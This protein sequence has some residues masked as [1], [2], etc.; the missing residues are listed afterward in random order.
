MPIYLD[1]QATTPVDAR[2]L[3]RMWPFFREKFG[4]AASWNHAFGQEAAAAVEQARQQLATLLHTTPD[5]LVFTS[6]AT[7]ANNL[8]LKGL[9]RRVPAGKHVVTTAI[10]HK[11]ILDPL[12]R[13][14]RQGTAVTHVPVD[15]LGRVDP[16]RIAAAIRP[17]TVL[18]SVMWANNEVG[19]IQPI[20]EIAEL[21]RERGVLFHTDAAQAVGKLSVD[22]SETPIDLLSLSAHKFYGPKGVGA[23][24]IRRGEPRI[25]LEP[26]FDGGGHEQH[27]RSGT[28]AVP[29]I[30][31]LG[32]AAE[33]AVAEQEAEGQ[34]LTWLAQRLWERLLAV[35]P[36][37]QRNGHP[38]ERIPGNLHISI[39]EINGA[40]LMTRLTEVAV[41]SG[42][43]CTTADPEP[44]HVLRA[45]G[46]PER[47]A[48]AS[49]RF[50]LGRE[51]TPA[52]V[53]FAAEYIGLMVRDLLGPAV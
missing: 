22:L 9:L 43:A 37:V 35:V 52:E 31:G 32:A 30:V 20:R 29:L 2:V 16:A 27:L 17:E 36:N 4:N 51:T 10:E 45:M 26:L 39:P 6:G 24:S 14:Q 21:C 1:H 8:A 50:G 12:K 11:A 48:L 13:L 49:L 40:A 7:E 38:T 23:L 53:D 15:A 42:S 19:T 46:V 25:L 5:T 3:D 18:V 41:S 33:I 44:S 28:L 47:L 34:R